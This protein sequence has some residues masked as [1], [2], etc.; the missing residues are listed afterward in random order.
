MT[1]TGRKWTEQLRRDKDWKRRREA[2]LALGY[3]C[4][5]SSYPDLVRSLDDPDCA[6]RQAAILSIGRLGVSEAV[7]ELTKP[8]VLAS[9]D[10]ATRRT[11]IAV[12]GEIGGV[13][14]ADVIS[15]SID[16]PDWTVK[17]EAISVVSKLIDRLSENAAP[18]SARALVRMLPIND[19]DIRG[20]TIR[21][22]GE[23]GQSA[24]HVL[25][26][27]LGVESKCVRSGAAAALG[28]IAGV[29]AAR[30]LRGLDPVRGAVRSRPGRRG[31]TTCEV[32]SCS[33][34]RKGAGICFGGTTRCPPCP[35]RGRSTTPYRRP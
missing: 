13:A 19:P 17:I 18:E 23:F 22:L 1:G 11:A 24:M 10:P 34:P 8:K 2:A 4:E 9:E 6:V 16:D 27:A 7:A 5:A 3:L 28:L 32:S 25:V 29:N 15:E 33:F 26:E 30:E 12:L 14:I 31:I 35:T 21:A 20:K